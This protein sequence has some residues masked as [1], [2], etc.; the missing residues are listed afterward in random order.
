MMRLMARKCSQGTFWQVDWDPGPKWIGKISSL[1]VSLDY[2]DQDR[3]EIQIQGFS[4]ERGGGWY[5]W[6]V[7]SMEHA[8]NTLQLENLNLIE[9]SYTIIFHFF[10]F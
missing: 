3:I 7:E 9:N 10:H 2:M 6:F 4:M 8:H 5:I 1:C